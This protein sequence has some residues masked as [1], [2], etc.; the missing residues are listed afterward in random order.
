MLHWGELEVPFTVSANT[1]EVVLANMERELRNLPRFFWNGWNQIAGFALQTQTRMDEAVGWIDQSLAINRN[2]TNLGTKIALLTALGR[3]SEAD[4]LENEFLTIATESDVNTYGYLL[5]TAGR[6]AEAIAIFR[7]NVQDH[8][9]S[10][11]VHD[12]LGEALAAAG[13]TA[14]AIRHYEHAR[15]LAPP[16]QLARIDGILGQLQSAN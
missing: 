8:P 15:S 10:W 2:G 16:P 1:P 14:E 4:A 3:T 11:N 13:Q 9:D 12:S 7:K 6:Q 5:L